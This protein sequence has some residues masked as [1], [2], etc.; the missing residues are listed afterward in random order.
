MHQADAIGAARVVAGL[1]DFAGRFGNRFGWWTPAPL[2]ARLA[3][4]GGTF[5]S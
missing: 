1:D 5:I 2:L 3:A 4:K